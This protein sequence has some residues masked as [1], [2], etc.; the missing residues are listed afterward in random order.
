MSGQPSL[1]HP[2]SSRAGW[3]TREF[4]TGLLVNLVSSAMFLAS[5]VGI[6]VLAG[7]ALGPSEYGEFGVLLTVALLLNVVISSGLG[8]ATS[9][10]VAR[11]P[12]NARRV[13]RRYLQF[14]T[15]MALLA[16]LG[17]FAT[18]RW[19]LPGLH[20]V[21]DPR[22]ALLVGGLLVV[23]APGSVIIAALYAL[24]RGT[25]AGVS[26]I[27]AHITKVALGAMLLALA[28]GGFGLLLA[29]GIANLVPVIGGLRHV[30]ARGDDERHGPRDQRERVN[31]GF[32]VPATL[33]AVAINA[34]AAIDV[35]VAKVTLSAADAGQY[36]AAST[37]AKIPITIS[38]SMVLVIYPLLV[39]LGTRSS[40]SS[41]SD[42]PNPSPRRVRWLMLSLLVLTGLGVFAL[43]PPLIRSVYG[44]DYSAAAGLARWLAP[45]F[46]LAA[47]GLALSHLAVAS[48]G[49]TRVSAV[50][51]AATVVYSTAVLLLADGTATGLVRGS[52]AGCLVSV[53]AALV[54][55]YAGGRGARRPGTGPSTAG[56][57]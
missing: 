47:C 49:A 11:A 25:Y 43:A 31:F 15:T 24:G 56:D 5:G 48:R 26:L 22:S 12:G 53:V 37:L 44:A 41:T 38:T 32:L 39:R 20:L 7:W 23:Y 54:V 9:D 13:S 8:L 18:H 36:I 4:S 30:L 55:H 14:G 28:F 21:P 33:L 1:G 45:A 27:A 6:H 35:L 57:L 19:W 17:I 52:Y 40:G 3:P 16:G 2:R 46:T 42:V 50:V 29:Y 10:A 51:V 34:F